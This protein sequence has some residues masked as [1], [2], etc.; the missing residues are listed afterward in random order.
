MDAFHDHQKEILQIVADGS[1]NGKAQV[2]L[3]WRN[4]VLHCDV[5]NP[6]KQKD[7]E[8]FAAEVIRLKRR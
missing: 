5:I 3:I 6:A 8:R 7:R 2:K 1:R 4:E